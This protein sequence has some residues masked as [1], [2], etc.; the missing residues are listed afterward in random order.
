ME[1]V[2][3]N[4]ETI[5]WHTTCKGLHHI[6]NTVNFQHGHQLYIFFTGGNACKSNILRQQI[7]LYKLF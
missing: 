5:K 4:F 7:K 6:F 2:F 3:F 1:I